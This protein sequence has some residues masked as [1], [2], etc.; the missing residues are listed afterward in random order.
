MPKR[1]Q[2]YMDRQRL[3]F[4]EAAMACFRRKGVVATNLADI[5]EETGLSMGALYKH[6]ASRD[7]LLEAILLLRLERRNAMLHG[8]SWPELRAAILRLRDDHDSNP[9]W[10]EFL[11]MADL[12]E[13][14]RE[15]RLY[16][17]G[18]ILAQIE[19][20]LRR[21]AEAGEIALPFPPRQSAQLVSVIFDGSLIEMR[22][23]TRLRVSLDELAAYLDHAVGAQPGFRSAG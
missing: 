11:A 7:E 2:E 16:E 21:Y 6:F 19:Q 13:G 22:S 17:G 3:R 18:V 12:H 10:R 5:C 4:C 8:E 1:S 9:F 14:M 15:L 23:S 20:Q